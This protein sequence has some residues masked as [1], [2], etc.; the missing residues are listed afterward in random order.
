MLKNA[1][2]KLKIHLNDMTIQQPRISF[3]SNVTAKEEKDPERMKDLL[4]QQVY[5]SVLWQQSVQEM[6]KNGAD[7]FIEIGP[8]KTL[9]GFM[10]KI[11]RSV[12][13]YHVENLSELMELAKK[14]RQEC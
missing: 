8:G 9:S 13:V 11:N 5:S 12:T 2:E 4:S 1:G 10:K 14:R 6:I 3:Y 7:T